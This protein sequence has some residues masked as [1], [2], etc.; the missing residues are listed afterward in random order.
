MRGIRRRN[1]RCHF[2]STRSALVFDS[3]LKNKQ[4]EY[5]ASRVD[6]AEFE[7]LRTEVAKRVVDRIEDIQREF[8]Y[9]LDLGCHAGHVYEALNAQKGLGGAGATGGVVAVT[10]GDVSQACAA[11]AQ[12]SAEAHLYRDRCPAQTI[13]LDAG[14]DRDQA[15]GGLPFDDDT[16]DLVTS[17]MALHWCNDL[18]FTL[19]EVRRVLKP[20]GCFIGAML[21]GNTLNE[22]RE[23]MLIGETEREG[24]MSP[25]TSPMASPSEVGGLLSGA[26][27]TLPTVDVDTMVCQY[28]DAFMV[29]DELQGMG[30]SSASIGR[31][32]WPSTKPALNLDQESAA[33]RAVSRD[34]FLA[35]AATYHY[36]AAVFEEKTTQRSAGKDDGDDGEG[37]GG[38]SGQGSSTNLHELTVPA[39]FQVVYMI[40]WAPHGSQQKPDCRGTASRSLNEIS[41]TKTPGAGA[42]VVAVEK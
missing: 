1:V 6:A 18:P 17:S 5:A 15:G 28:S 31:R 29:M 7:Y 12:Q 22:L 39:T 30:E 10:Q 11:K 8:P 32:K 20:D 13:L 26:G 16:F 34:T 4:R 19:R 14:W 35:A 42:S 36:T 3:A 41:V 37:L 24:G 40:G 21:G 38:D 25:H 23:A 27:F 33:P 9:M 2:F